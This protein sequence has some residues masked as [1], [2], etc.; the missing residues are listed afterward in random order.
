MESLEEYS[1]LDYT[2]SI[3]EGY[4]E[5]PNVILN[6]GDKRISIDIVDEGKELEIWAS[7]KSGTFKFLGDYM[8]WLFKG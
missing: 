3:C 6:F 4:D 1:N 5:C 7:S 2:F 8:A